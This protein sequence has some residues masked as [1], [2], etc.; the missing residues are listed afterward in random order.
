MGES[1]DLQKSLSAWPLSLFDWVPQNLTQPINPGWSF[2]NV[3]VN[4]M[5]SSAPDVEQQV[6][7]QHSYGRQIGQLMNAVEVLVK[8]QPGAEEKPEFAEFLSLA[9]KIRNIK[10][11]DLDQRIKRLQNELDVL[12]ARKSA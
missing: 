7:S 10:K 11:N 12:Q 8:A 9:A 4:R 5:N 1:S 2:G 3:I 6:V